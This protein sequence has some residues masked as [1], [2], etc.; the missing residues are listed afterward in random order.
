MK[1]RNRIISIAMCFTIILVLFFSVYSI[2]ANASSGFIK[3]VDISSIIAFENAGTTFKYENG[4]P[5]DIFDILEDAGVNY[6]RIRVW[7]NPYDTEGNGY[8]GGNNDLYKAKLIGLRATQHGM[9][10]MIDFQYS[11]FW[12]DPA[13]QYAPKEWMNFTVHEK[14]I[15]IY[16]YTFDSLRT[17]IDAGVDVGVVQIGNETQ[18][19]LC[20]MGGL[21]DGTWNLSTGVANGLKNG[22]WAVD[23]INSFYGK[24]GSNKILKVVHFTD[25]NTTA[26]WYAEQLESQS[27]D[28]DVFA[29]SA[30]PFW[31]GAPSNLALSLVNIAST[32]DK[33]VMVA[34]TAYPYTFDNADSQGNN[35]SSL[36][37]MSFSGYE[38]STYGQKEAIKAVMDAVNTVNYQSGTEGYG[39]G[40]FYWE[41][42]WIGT[43]AS[44]C[45]NYGT[46][47]ASAKSGDYELLFNSS[48]EEY[49]ESDCGSSWDNMALFDSNG[50]ALPSLQL[51]NEISY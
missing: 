51:F 46:G 23:D 18:G 17:L 43:N 15:A 28:Y 47:F 14:G 21:Y 11:D 26:S 36:N 30:Y 20:G 29:V 35:I 10:C 31:H 3:G 4:T 2:D 24:T 16:N 44:D 49:S 41:P 25:P 19:S 42:T 1:I 13:K 48:V 33:K 6:V 7:N 50:K 32:Y 8:G 5:A 39:L 27:V 22:C 40:G 34:E 45:L 12:A 38:I 9:K 37:D